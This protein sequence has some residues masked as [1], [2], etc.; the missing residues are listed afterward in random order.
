MK[1]HNTF[2]VIFF[3]LLTNISFSQTIKSPNYGWPVNTSGNPNHRGN[4]IGTPGE[5][6][7]PYLYTTVHRFHL[8]LDISGNTRDIYSIENGHFQ[9]NFSGIG[10]NRRM[11]INGS[12]Y[13]HVVEDQFLKTGTPYVN[14]NDHLGEYH[15]DANHLHYQT[16]GA[17]PL[18]Y[19]LYSF[20]DNAVPT[21]DSWSFRKN[22]HSFT[23]CAVLF[24]EITLNGNKYPLLYDKI[25]MTVQTIDER[26]DPAGNGNGGNVA[27]NRFL[28]EILDR[29]LTSISGPQ[30][31]IDFSIIPANYNAVI[32]TFGYGTS[33]NPPVFKYIVTNSLEVPY[34]RY[35]NS[36]LKT[37][38]TETWP[39][40]NSLD[41][42]IIDE[43]IYKDGLNKVK[44]SISDIDYYSN[45][46]NTYSSMVDVIIDNFLPYIRKVEIFSNS[47]KT[48]SSEWRWDPIN[49]QLNFTPDILNQSVRDNLDATIIV[50]TS[51]PMKNLN[52]L[53]NGLMTSSENCSVVLGTN[54]KEWKLTIPAANIAG[55]AGTYTISINGSDYA[56]NPVWGFSTQTLM[57]AANIPVRQSD[58]SWL[59]PAPAGMQPDTRHLLQIISSDF[60]DFTA[61]PVS[62]NSPLQVAFTN[63]STTSCHGWL[64]HF[65]GGSPST[66]NLQDP[67]ITYTNSG[68]FN[69]SYDV[70]LE[71]VNSS[72]IPV[73]S[74]IKKNYITIYGSGN[75]LNANFSA[76]KTTLYPGE[77]VTFSDLSTGDPVSW[78]WDFGDGKT[79]SIQNPVRSYSNPGKYTVKLKIRDNTGAEQEIEK[80]NYIT[81][82]NGV[83][84][85]N[86]NSSVT[87]VSVGYPVNFYDASTGNPGQW[88]WYF[89][90]GQPSYFYG[91]N[92]PSVIYNNKGMY[93]VRLVVK[94]AG[95]MD[96]EFKKM[97]IIVSTGGIEFTWDRVCY[98]D[99]TMIT[100]HD[101]TK[102]FYSAYDRVWTLTDPSGITQTSN[103]MTPTL[104]LTGPGI[105]NIR[106]DLYDLSSNPLGS[107][108]DNFEIFM[109]DPTHCENKIQDYDEEGLDCGGCSCMPCGTLDH[110]KNFIKDEDETDVDCGGSCGP[111]IPPCMGIYKYWENDNRLPELSQFQDFIVGRNN[112]VIKNGEKKSF[113]AGNEISLEPDFIAELGS[114][115]T[116][117]LVYCKC[118]ELGYSNFI[119]ENKSKYWGW[120]LTPNGDGVNDN[121]ILKANWATYYDFEV[122]QYHSTIIPG[123]TGWYSIYHSEG[124]IY[125]I[126]VILWNGT[127]GVKFKYNWYNDY[128]VYKLKLYACNGDTWESLWR[129]YTWDH[130][131]PVEITKN[132][133]DIR[134][135]PNPTNNKIT[136]SIQNQESDTVSVEIIDMSGNIVFSIPDVPSNPYD[137]DITKFSKGVFIV[138]LKDG[139][140]IISKQIIKL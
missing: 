109:K 10:Y 27:P 68:S 118:K 102:G 139:E 16:F 121:L 87:S 110:C 122:F 34:D 97:Y 70:T 23:N 133:P 9:V 96:E 91:Q 24:S 114:D 136:I 132:N 59:P 135:Y 95:V 103:M 32:T 92:P 11:E 63:Q 36:L 84:N 111:C 140:T 101:L 15:P 128:Y 83:L 127:D 113:I 71:A 49:G 131:A 52:V 100:F 99:Q 33:F 12:I 64:W 60:V 65:P 108:I 25:D 81:V 80:T 72:G 134:V 67:V 98:P 124:P 112:T 8:G 78:E 20:T 66:S 50:T 119:D 51:E 48:Y 37:N 40:N 46:K 88:E 1:Y 47:N 61:S 73:K 94:K 76:D 82:S 137:I 130:K 77:G 19:A 104:P 125:S 22:G 126:P 17:N 89:Y 35:W 129:I 57:A 26:L 58:G 21:I 105:Y 54:D 41:A 62:G 44:F 117:S 55:K 69:A 13:W 43:A 75:N 38:T 138:R 53:I 3:V 120:I 93:D 39:G 86:F 6:R 5:Y 14:F 18:T 7:T 123:K 115:F 90:G 107:A 2:F 28:W 29:N 56:S 106:L 31:F 79:A 45:P 42:R 85:A 74:E 116:A 30:C 4:I